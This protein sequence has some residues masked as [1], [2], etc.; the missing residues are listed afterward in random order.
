MG[1][2]MLASTAMTS[3]SIAQG[4]LIN[5]NGEKLY[6]EVQGQG[7]PLVLIH[8]WSLN[9]RMWDP[10][11]HALGSHFRI[12]RYDRRGFGRSSGTEDMSWEAADLSALLDSLGIRSAHLLGMSQGGRVALA[13]VRAHPDRVSSLILHGS[14]PPDGFPLPWTGPDRT[15]FAAWGQLAREKGLDAFRQEWSHHPLMRIPD[16]RPAARAKLDQLLGAYR[17]ERF[18][19]PANPVG[20]DTAAKMDDLSRITAPTLIVVGSDETPYLRLVANVYAYYIPSARLEIV[21]GGGHMVNII[22]PGHYNATILKFLES[23]ATHRR[24]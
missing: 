24:K 20:P 9:L 23:V 21:P 5:V 7:E 15:D 22:E 14:S 2:A 11:V 18:V 6:A 13:F 17:G 4:R 8:G 1:V 16:N 3:P 12:I 19:H 10:Q